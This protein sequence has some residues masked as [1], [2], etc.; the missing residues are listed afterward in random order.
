MIAQRVLHRVRVPGVQG[1]ELVHDPELV[2]RLFDEELNR[3]LGEGQTATDAA[4]AASLRQ[5][6]EL[7]EG[8]V[9]GIL[10]AQGTPV[11]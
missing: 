4:A 2:S 10:E 11:R 5:S 7:S 8:M 6:R 3:L 9:L 1:G